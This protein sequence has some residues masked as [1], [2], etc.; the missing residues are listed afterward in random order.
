VDVAK[1]RYSPCV[2]LELTFMD[3]R[4]RD[5]HYTERKADLHVRLESAQLRDRRASTYRCKIGELPLEGW[6]VPKRLKLLV[7]IIDSR[8][9]ISLLMGRHCAENL[10]DV[11]MEWV[12][13]WL[14]PRSPI[15]W[16]FETILRT[17]EGDGSA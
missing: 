9:A 12:R 11:R 7:V 10:Q 3:V 2:N 16:T 1:A 13:T 5:S 15:A 6:H 14:E 17:E 4:R 8:E